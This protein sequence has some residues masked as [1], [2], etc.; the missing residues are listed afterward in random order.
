MTSEEFSNEFDILLNTYAADGVITVDEYDK[1]VFLTKAQESLVIDLYTGRLQQIGGF[2]L[3]EEIK[4]YL[5]ELVK[6]Y[7][8]SDKVDYNTKVDSRSIFFK[9]P[10]DLWFVTYESATIKSDD[11]FN[12]KEISIKPCNQD[13]YSKSKDN[14]FRGPTKRYALRLDVEGSIVELISVFDLSRYLVRYLSKPQPI[15][16]VDLPQDGN[17]Y[18]LSINGVTK[19]TECS[20]NPALH[21]TILEKAVQMALVS[22]SMNQRQ[23]QPQQQQQE[24]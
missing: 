3:T 13:D 12:G 19:K 9:L 8:T 14:P 16:T 7:V 15:I 22:K 20:L 2:E 18:D 6:T 11:C 21:R 17:G 10:S 24:Q 1:S 5:N 23:Q 4:R